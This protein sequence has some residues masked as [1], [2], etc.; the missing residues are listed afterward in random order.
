M[1]TTVPYRTF[2]G[3][4]TFADP[5]VRPAARLR[6]VAPAVA[7]SRAAAGDA[8]RTLVR[9]AS[10][11]DHRALAQIVRRNAGL[12]RA[13]ALGI[14]RSSSDADDVVQETF[15]AAWTHLGAMADG[16]AVTG[17]LVTTVRRRSYD[18]LRGSVAQRRT[19]L[20]DS[21]PASTDRAP[22]AVAER[23]SLV[24]AAQRVLDAMPSLQR[25]CWELRHL[26]RHS[27][28]AIAL[29]LDVPV[30]TVRG[31]LAR[32]RVVVER[33]LAPWR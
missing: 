29:E 26:E 24:V 21:M 27:Y 11:G 32:A 8:D 9:R 3:P 12:L 15:I 5:P 14:L 28:E 19:G 10:A 18:R 30:S 22:A 1:L 6:A 16:A 33:E 31:Q 20:D 23:A 4:L 25:R 13:T 7:L 2:V 17:W